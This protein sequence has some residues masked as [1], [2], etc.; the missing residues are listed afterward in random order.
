[1][2]IFARSW[3]KIKRVVHAWRNPGRLSSSPYAKY[4]ENFDFDGKRLL[5]LGCG[6]AHW[7]FPNVVNLDGES[8]SNADVIWNL[9]KTPLPFKDEEFDMIIANHILEHV[10]DWWNCFKE[11]SRILKTGGRLEVWLPGNGNDSQL[12]YRDHINMINQCS[13]AGISGYYRNQ[14]NAWERNQFDEDINR[15]EL[16]D[17]LAH[18][19]NQWWIE[20]APT[21]IKTLIAKH[22]RNTVYEIGFVFKKLPEKDLGLTNG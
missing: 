22:L 14:G 12:G 13:F 10:P 11:C 16:V 19:E 6:H 7:K 21:R 3:R 8:N 17:Q 2:N 20:I 18:L 5:N 9:G 15:L 1:M 4:P